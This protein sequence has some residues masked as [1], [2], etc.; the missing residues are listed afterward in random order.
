MNRIV[1]EPELAALFDG[2]DEVWWVERGDAAGNTTHY[3]VPPARWAEQQVELVTRSPLWGHDAIGRG[4]SDPG[5]P[6]AVVTV[7]VLPVLGMDD[8]PHADCVRQMWTQPRH[9]RRRRHRRGDGPQW[10]LWRE[11]DAKATPITLPRSPVPG[12]N[13]VIRLV[14]K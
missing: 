10:F 2:A 13:Y 9:P 1:I 8:I 3:Y 12:E 4:D 5:I 6:V 14:K 11:D 7:E